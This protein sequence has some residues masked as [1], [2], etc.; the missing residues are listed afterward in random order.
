M[1]RNTFGGRCTVPG[2][3]VY[4]APGAG[5][6]VPDG[7]RLRLRCRPDCVGTR[8]AAT[9]LPARTQT[10][11]AIRIPPN[12]TEA[13]ANRFPG[14]CVGCS[15]YIEAE[16]GRLAPG[17]SGPRTPRCPVCCEV[18]F[19]SDRWNEEDQNPDLSWLPQTVPAGCAPT[20]ALRV[21]TLTR[22]CWSRRCAR[23]TVCVVGLRPQLPARVD[24]LAWNVDRTSLAWLKPLLADAGQ[25]PLAESIKSRWSRT[26]G[27]RYLSNGCQHCD[28]LQGAFP[29]DEDV[30]EAV[31][32]GGVDALDTAATVQAS[33]LDWWEVVHGHDGHGSGVLM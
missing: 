18:A 12:W 25:Q 6:L 15:V 21:L 1:R 26:E 2:C 31:Q 14:P 32:D 3:R 23:P 4:V 29:L 8:P 22:T 9:A 27:A 33:S 11:S 10:A 13:S 28:A 17:D 24:P 19:R 20:I 30:A 7:D 5:I 16:A